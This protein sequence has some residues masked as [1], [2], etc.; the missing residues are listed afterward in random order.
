MKPISAQTDSQKVAPSRT[1]IFADEL[2][3]ALVRPIESALGSIDA[4]FKVI[5]QTN[6]MQYFTSHES[7]L[8]P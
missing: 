2:I 3:H 4:A 7:R 8:L 6:L 1:L 5:N